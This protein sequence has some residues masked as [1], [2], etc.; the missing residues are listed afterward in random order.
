LTAIAAL[1]IGAGE[2]AAFLHEGIDERALE[3]IR[4]GERTGRPLGGE[5]FVRR[6]EGL[7]GR[8]LTRQK[9]GPKPRN[10]ELGG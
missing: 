6:L 9:P 1:G 8:Q 4:A 3:T 5:A 2:W 7:T 10:R